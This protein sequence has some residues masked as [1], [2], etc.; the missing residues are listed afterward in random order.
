M[1]FWKIDLTSLKMHMHGIVEQLSFDLQAAFPESKGFSTTNLWYMKQW[2][3]FIRIHSQNST[4]LVE[5]Y[6]LLKNRSKQN[7]H[8]LLF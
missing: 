1:S 7:S 6:I 3:R 2:Y 4:N 5:K 8:R